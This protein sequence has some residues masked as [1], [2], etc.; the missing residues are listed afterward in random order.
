MKIL[1]FSETGLLPR[2]GLTFPRAPFFNTAMGPST[3]TEPGGKCPSVTRGGRSRGSTLSVSAKEGIGVTECRGIFG[4][5]MAPLTQRSKH[6]P[7]QKPE[8]PDRFAPKILDGVLC[9]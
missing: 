5:K 1:N 6:L 2:R 3:A 9:V 7:I 8:S 4:G